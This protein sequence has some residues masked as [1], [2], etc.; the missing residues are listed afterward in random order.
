MKMFETKIIPF[1]EGKILTVTELPG[2]I[3]RYKFNN[4]E[5]N[6]FQL[7]LQNLNIINSN[8]DYLG[9]QP[10]LLVNL[11]EKFS[12]VDCFDTNFQSNYHVSYSSI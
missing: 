11:D 5:K 12:R 7:N 9:S 3:I 1:R 10:K 6:I 4:T 8:N 2:N